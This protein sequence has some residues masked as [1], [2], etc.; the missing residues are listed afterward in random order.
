MAYACT[1]WPRGGGGMLVMRQRLP[2]SVI[3]IEPKSVHRALRAPLQCD[4]Q[5][6]VSSPL[7][8]AQEGLQV[9]WQTP[10]RIHAPTSQ[11]SHVVVFQ[12]AGRALQ[13]APGGNTWGA[14]QCSMQHPPGLSTASR[15]PPHGRDAAAALRSGTL[16]SQPT[17]KQPHAPDTKTYERR[18]LQNC[19]GNCA[20][21]VSEQAT[22]APH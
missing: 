12:Q 22:A 3:T 16:I 6:V 13:G 7:P 8:A 9:L 4:A 10:D 17:H 19:R 15:R 14:C 11:W 1:C 18:P 2:P 20:S 5:G 21:P